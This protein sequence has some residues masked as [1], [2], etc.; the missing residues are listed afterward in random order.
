MALLQVAV[1]A[2]VLKGPH[3]RSA[4]LSTH[5]AL[6]RAVSH[7]TSLVS[8]ALSGFLQAAKNLEK[9]RKQQKQILYVENHFKRQERTQKIGEKVMKV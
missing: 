5:H 2:L 9:S 3:A 7:M 8:S 6:Y 4:G 1:R